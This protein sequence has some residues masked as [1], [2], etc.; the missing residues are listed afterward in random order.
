MNSILIT[1]GDGGIANGI[2]LYLE[3]K[4]YVVLSPTRQEFDVTDFSSSY[5]E[6][7]CPD[8]LINCAGYILPGLIKD[9][10]VDVVQTHFL[11]NT[12][13]PFVCTQKMIK[14]GGKLIINIGSTSSFEG[15]EEWSAYCMSKAAIL[16]LTESC[17]REGIRCYSI[18][19]ART[20]T[21]M[22]DVLFPNEDKTT[23]MDPGVIANWVYML[24]NRDVDVANGSH[25]IVKK[26][27]VFI[28]PMRECPK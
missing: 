24:I 27:R 10:S 22:R 21:K 9:T 19:P 18:N 15:R 26:D 3:S 1:G 5:I 16:S 23:L 11:I 6:K 20:R 4:G 7:N 12:V 28:L 8:V 17:A 2:R 13:G 14:T 25:L